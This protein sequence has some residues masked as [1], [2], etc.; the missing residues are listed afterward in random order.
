M[1]DVRHGV[2]V[3]QQQIQRASLPR[4]IAV[5][6]AEA[7]H[8]QPLDKAQ[9]EAQ[10]TLEILWPVPQQTF[11]HEIEIAPALAVEVHGFWNDGRDDSTKNL[12]VDFKRHVPLPWTR[13]A[14]TMCRREAGASHASPNG[15]L[16][17]SSSTSRNRQ[18]RGKAQ[19]PETC[20]LHIQRKLLRLYFFG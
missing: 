17:D 20:R 1:A 8:G 7:Q 16:H 2:A 11:D 10:L 18:V 15:L 13:V 19:A 3:H 5:L 6:S 14:T 12:G 9:K 4:R